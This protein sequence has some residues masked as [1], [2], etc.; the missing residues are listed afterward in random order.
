MIRFTDVTEAVGVAAVQGELLHHA[1]QDLGEE[2]RLA[3]VGTQGLPEELWE[4]FGRVEREVDHLRKLI[5]G[6]S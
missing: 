6:Q 1:V 5:G 4:A 3:P 2:M